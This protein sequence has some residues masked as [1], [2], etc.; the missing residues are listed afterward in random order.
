MQG[1]KE[2][3]VYVLVEIQNCYGV[4]MMIFEDI[5]SDEETAH[6]IRLERERKT[7]FKYEVIPWLLYDF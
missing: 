1:I 6:R 2:T 5:F 7:E 3:T 4:D